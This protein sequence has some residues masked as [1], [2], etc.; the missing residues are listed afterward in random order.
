MLKIC[1]RPKSPYW[2]M[3]GTVRGQSIEESTG[4]A[5]KKLAEEI[6]AKREN[7]IINEAVYGKTVIMTFAHALADYLEHGAGN[8]RFLTPLLDHFNTTLLKDIDQHAIDLAAKKLYPNAG[9]ATRN[10][11]VYTPVSAILRHAA[12]KKWCDVPILAR[13]KQP[14]GKLRWLK[15]EEAEKLV[16]ACAPHLKPLVV[17]LLYTGARAGE[18]IWLD[19]SNV[20]LDKAQVTFVKT[21]NGEARSVPL[22]PR[23]V[24]SIA[25]LPHRDGAVFLT[26]KGNPYERPD[27]GKDA[28]TSAGTHIGSAFKTAC[29]RAGLGWIVPGKG[30]QP[31]FKTDVTPHVCRHT[32]A[33]WHYQANRDLTALQKLGGWKT[34]AMVFR[35]AHANVEEHAKGIQ[36]LPWGNQGEKSQEKTAIS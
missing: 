6:R 36:N 4:T 33:T 17:F 10:R 29:K 9:P 22:H 7:E 35:Y 27:P 34:V 30:K 5:D 14:K 23:V 18:A 3:R 19:W 31:V 1:K 8:K 28:D 2:I 32:W 11:Q 15:P 26:H 16:E 24:Q 21:K 20:N 13:P 25:N 12:R